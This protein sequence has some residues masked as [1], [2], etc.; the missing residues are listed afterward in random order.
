MKT[1]M[2]FQY[3]FH[4]GT[5]YV[6]STMKYAVNYIPGHE[7]IESRIAILGLWG[8]KMLV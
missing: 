2:R 6:N 3:I 7:K 1:C 8:T 4:N 5:F